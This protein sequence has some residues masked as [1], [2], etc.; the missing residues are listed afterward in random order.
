M[1]GS[2]RSHSAVLDEDDGDADRAEEASPR[3][4]DRPVGDQAQL[5]GALAVEVAVL[6]ELGQG[7]AGSL[8]VI[9][10]A[11]RFHFEDDVRA[12]GRDGTEVDRAWDLFDLTPP[13]LGDSLMK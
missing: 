4:A 10:P 6:Q 12:I 13:G 5:V 11:E 7:R 9:S 8:H 1:K 3:I 2:S